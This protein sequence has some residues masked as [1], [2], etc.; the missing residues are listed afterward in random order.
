MK[1]LLR[2]LACCLAVTT[3]ATLHAAA[4]AAP[5]LSPRLQ[6]LAARIADIDAQA[7]RIDD[8]NQIRNLQRI[9]GYYYDEA[10]WDQVVDLFA[11]N[12]TLEVGQHGVYVGRDSIRRYFLGLTGG[13]IGLQHGELSNQAQLSPVITLA[14]DGR[15]AN[16][17]WRV[18]IQDAVHGS[19]AN[20][21][22]GV[23]ENAYVKE[24]GVWK[25]Q[26]LHL[27]LRFHAPYEKGW[28][29]TDA[30][31]NAR[32]G[33]STARADRAPSSRH[34]TWPEHFIAPMH[35]ANETAGAYRLLTPARAPVRSAAPAPAGA[36]AAPT[37]SALEAQVRAL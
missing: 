9:Y 7:G 20:W 5:D 27:Y 3:T 35:Y 28:T 26:R 12:A 16:G 14:P 18:L 29:A 33:R 17:R 11:S 15:A 6:Q 32:Y 36:D 34:G 2:I 25:I 10:L 24:D 22:S 1:P 8:Y 21:G 31:L 4:P 30:A 37:S 19:S 23:Y 13:R